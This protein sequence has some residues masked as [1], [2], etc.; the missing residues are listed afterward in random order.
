MLLITEHLEAYDTPHYTTIF[1]L[2]SESLADILVD[3]VSLLLKE[4]MFQCREQPPGDWS[5]AAYTLIGREDLARQYEK[6]SGESLSQDR[7]QAMTCI[8]GVKEEEDGMEHLH[9]QV[10]K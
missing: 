4:A 9:Q 10:R 6:H 2:I 3:G 1:I 7:Q 8:K 5:K